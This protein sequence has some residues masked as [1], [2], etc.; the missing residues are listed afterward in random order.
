MSFKS[1][2]KDLDGWF[3]H[4][5]WFR[6]FRCFGAMVGSSDQVVISLAGLPYGRALDMCI[7]NVLWVRS[8]V[9]LVEMLK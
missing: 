4:N 5:D 2:A 9:L 7:Q 3:Q 1:R 8:L 6:T